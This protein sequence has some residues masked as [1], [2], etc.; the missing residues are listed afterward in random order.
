MSTQR[1][2]AT[3]E[4]PEPPV[5][6]RA[7]RFLRAHKPWSMAAA[8]LLLAAFL[9]PLYWRANPSGS[10]S[11]WAVIERPA[12]VSDRY[13]GDTT[14]EELLRA[15]TARTENAPAWL[16][17]GYRRI[18]RGDIESGVAALK[19]AAEAEGGALADSARWLRA[20]VYLKNYQVPEAMAE[21]DAVVALGGDHKDR[22]KTL[23]QQ[24]QKPRAQKN[25][26]P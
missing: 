21:L 8:A 11:D 16:E 3:P 22:A 4:V 15:A 25:R 6:V 23:R 17:L 2:P 20:N 26:A 24:I 13:R 14:E 5:A 1:A 9:L 7:G 10:P 18:E 19:R 12:L